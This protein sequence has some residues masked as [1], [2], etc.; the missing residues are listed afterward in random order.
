MLFPLLMWQPEESKL[1][2]QENKLVQRREYSFKSGYQD[3]L[4]SYAL[5]TSFLI[6]EG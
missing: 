5:L 6:F 1:V 4:S 3:F 2:L